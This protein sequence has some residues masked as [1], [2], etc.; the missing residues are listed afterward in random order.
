V[1]FFL[2]QVSRIW[3]KKDYWIRITVTDFWL[4]GVQVYPCFLGKRLI[5]S[6]EETQLE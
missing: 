3:Y 1:I 4:S 6:G 5:V 2:T